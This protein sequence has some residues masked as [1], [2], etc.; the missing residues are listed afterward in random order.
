M[1]TQLPSSH[2]LRVFL[3]NILVKTWYMS[4]IGSLY[5]HSES[6]QNQWVIKL[7]FIR[8]V[9]EEIELAEFLSKAHELRYSV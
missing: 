4:K 2:N 1:K 3:L 7:A 9:Y 5:G 8:Y 6:T